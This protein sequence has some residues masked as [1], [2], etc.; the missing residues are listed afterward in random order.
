VNQFPLSGS[1]STDLIQPANISDWT[2][3]NLSRG[4]DWPNH[5]FHLL[6]MATVSPDGRPAARIMTNRGA[7]RSSGRMWFYT[8]LDTPKV[9]DI[10]ASHLVCFIGYDSTSGVQLRISGSATLHQHGPLA[11]QHWQHVSDVSRWLFNLSPEQGAAAVGIDPRLPHDQNLLAKGLT[12]KA[13]S[14]FA[15]LEVIIDTIDWHQTDGSRQCRAVMHGRD[16]WRA[17]VV[18]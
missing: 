18:D 11:D 6:T 4:A 5:P 1:T 16:Q 3:I 2:W 13:R 15:V 12:A 8:R 10:R 14:Q 7:D 17:S 9:A